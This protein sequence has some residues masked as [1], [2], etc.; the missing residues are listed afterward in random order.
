MTKNQQIKHTLQQTKKRRKSQTLVCF[1]LKISKNKLPKSTI[2]KLHQ[3]FLETKWFYN[4]FLASDRTLSYKTK[5]VQV[6]NKDKE[7]EQKELILLSSQM[8][9]SLITKVKD[10][11]H[12]LHTLKM[13]GHKVGRLKFKKELNSIPLKQHN[14]TFTIFPTYIKVEKIK[15]KLPI[16]GFDQITDYCTKNNIEL[17]DV[18]FTKANFIRRAT[19]FFLHVTIAVPKVKKYK[20]TPKEAVGIDFGCQTQ[21][22]LSNGIEAVKIEYV[23]PPNKKVKTLHKGIS[24]SKKVNG[25]KSRTKNKFKK[26]LAL[27]KEYEHIS[28]QRKDIAN[29]VVRCLNESY[30]YVCYQDDNIHGWGKNHGKKISHTGIGRIKSDIKKKPLTPIEV[31]RFFPSTQLCPKCDTRTKHGVSQR[32]FECSS[33]LYKEDRDIK[34]AKIIRHEGLKQIKDLKG[35]EQTSMENLTSL[36]ISN[37]KKLGVSISYFL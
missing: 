5:S 33:C 12:T 21:L 18:E 35:L 23:V 22:T 27:R 8:K 11:I 32:I 29:K 2:K 37:L 9:Q 24:R 31:D 30:E 10:N 13:K 16:R 36:L 7:F 19:N 14:K 34:S 17:K 3:L 25:K 4:A 26:Q 6:R 28:N 20:T 1:E 15:H